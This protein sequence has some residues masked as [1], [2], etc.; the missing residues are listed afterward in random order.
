MNSFKKNLIVMNIILVSVFLVFFL[1]II[2]PFFQ[3]IR[4]NSEALFEARK[5]LVLLENEPTNILDSLK[6]DL[7]TAEEDL[8]K[9]NSFFIDKDFPIEIIKFWEKTAEET[10]VKI[11]ISSPS[12]ASEETEE[13]PFIIFQ[14]NV[15]SSFNNFLRFLEKIENSPYLVVVKEISIK[16]S[17][18]TQEVSGSSSKNNVSVFLSIKVYTKNESSN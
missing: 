3:N 16:K 6:K 9:I 7:K 15:I 12:V 4:R 13:W 1:L 10:N 8:N 2:Y 14:I 17:E 18:Q 5:S 11:D